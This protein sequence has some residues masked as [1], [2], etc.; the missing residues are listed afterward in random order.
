M[1]SDYLVEKKKIINSYIIKEKP[2][3]LLDEATSS[4]DP[5]QKKFKMHLTL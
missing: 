1:V 3:I 4:L 5:K 2:I